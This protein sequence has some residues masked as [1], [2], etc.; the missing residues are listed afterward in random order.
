[1]PAG[2][3]ATQ[4][5]GGVDAGGFSALTARQR[6][7]L[8]EAV[9]RAEI[10]SRAEFSVHLGRTLGDDPRAY[11]ERLHATLKT[12][13]RSV[14]IHVDPSGRVLEIVSGAWVRQRL[15]D[16][17]A[18][19]AATAMKTSFAEGDLLGGL[20]RGIALLAEHIRS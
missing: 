19:L 16:P 7:Q 6:F 9:R 13:E 3:P 12:P 5:R 20:T 11:A 14:L 2:E 1:M 17:E 18:E 4:R 15:T 10:A 8:H